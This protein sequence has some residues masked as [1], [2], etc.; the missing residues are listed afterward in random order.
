[1]L[2][3]I[4]TNTAPP[5]SFHY[6]DKDTG[7][8]FN[9]MNMGDLVKAVI[10]HRSANKLDVKDMA[11][12]VEDWLCTKMPYG[13]CED[14]NA[15]LSGGPHMFAANTVNRTIAV[16]KAGKDR[17]KVSKTEAI[18]RA[19][20][21]VSCANNVSFTGCSSCRGVRAIK[22][23]MMAGCSVPQSADLQ[24]CSSTGIM[25]EF[26]V[27]TEIEVLSKV[28]GAALSKCPDKCWLKGQ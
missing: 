9:A 15:R 27:F 10:A 23:E 8:H 6:T 4:K 21:C 12:I 2:K 11:V 18:R 14:E 7:F 16:Y 19:K 17:A 5:G 24:A 28:L 20:I 26:A 25:N 1:M 13:I 3:L 22:A